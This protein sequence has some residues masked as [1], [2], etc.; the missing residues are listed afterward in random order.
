[1]SLSKYFRLKKFIRNFLKFLENIPFTVTEE[2]VRKRAE[3]N[4]G[5]I[6]SLEELA[7]Y[8]LDIIK[9]D[10]LQN[11]CRELQILFLQNN[12]ISRIGK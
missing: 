9:I 4:E 11:W 3:H 2:L 12:L 10:R 5:D 8:Q 6:G 1:M 7:L